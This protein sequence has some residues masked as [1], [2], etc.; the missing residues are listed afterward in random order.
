MGYSFPEDGYC[1]YRMMTDLKN[2][3]GLMGEEAAPLCVSMVSSHG[4]TPTGPELPSTSTMAL[5]LVSQR[6]LFSHGCSAL[7]TS[8]LVHPIPSPPCPDVDC[9]DC[10]RLEAA[11]AGCTQL[12]STMQCLQPS[13]LLKS[14]RLPRSPL[15]GSGQ[16]HDVEVVT[17]LFW[18]PG[19]GEGRGFGEAKASFLCRPRSTESLTLEHL[20]SFDSGPLS[21][22]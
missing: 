1:F 19:E 8:V 16:H 13:A 18:W 6:S 5:G 15:S 10:G 7:A 14:I 9:V 4:L 2:S 21:L 12:M 22:A 20:Q 17:W 3:L 11:V